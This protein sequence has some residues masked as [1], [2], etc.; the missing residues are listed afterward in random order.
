MEAGASIDASATQSGNGGTV[1]LWSDVGNANSVTTAQGSLFAKGGANGG[2]GGR[3]E[4]SGALLITEGVSGSAAAP[5]GKAGEWLFDPTNVTIGTSGGAS[6]QNNGTSIAASSIEGLLNGGTSVT[7]T[8]YSGGGDLGDL[9]VNSGITKSSGNS[10]VT[11]TLRAANS[12][13]VNQAIAK[14]GGTG[15][16]NVVIDADNDTAASTAGSAPVR[17]GGGIVILEANLSTGGGSVTFGGTEVNG[18]NGGDLFVGGSNGITVSTSG[19]AVDVK[20]NLIIAN[21]STDGFAINSAGGAI[22]LRR[23][24]DSGNQYTAV[25][26]TRDW[27]QAFDHARTQPNSWLATIGSS[28]CRMVGRAANH[29]HQ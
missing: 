19:G 11:L 7:V 25:F 20:G 15:K 26:G 21:S 28:Q 23:A 12:I 1:V 29:W 22:N 16:L 27:Q 13:V 18:F 3:I 24:V 4:T 10:D 5:I 17:D 2:D 6:S 8:T 14:T 9:T